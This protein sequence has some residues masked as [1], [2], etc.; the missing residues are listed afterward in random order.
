MD[1]DAHSV[2]GNSPPGSVDFLALRQGVVQRAAVKASFFRIN[3]RI[4]FA[5]RVIFK[6]LYRN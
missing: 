3:P 6:S 5:S 2:M 4:V 1:I